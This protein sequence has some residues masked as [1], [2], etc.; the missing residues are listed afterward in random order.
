MNLKPSVIH[1]LISVLYMLTSD[2]YNSSSKQRPNY[3]KFFGLLKTF[4][5]K[6]IYSPYFYTVSPIVIVAEPSYKCAN[7]ILNIGLWFITREG[8]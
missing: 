2:S 5:C 3:C 8:L 1:I 4:G 6:G 7:T